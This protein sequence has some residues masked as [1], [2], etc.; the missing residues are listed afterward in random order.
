MTDCVFLCLVWTRTLS[1]DCFLKNVHSSMPL[2]Y[3]RNRTESPVLLI[4][5]ITGTP[6]NPVLGPHRF[7]TSPP[8]NPLWGSLLVEVISLFVKTPEICRHA[9]ADLGLLSGCRYYTD[10]HCYWSG[11][12]T[13]SYYSQYYTDLHRYCSDHQQILFSILYRPT[14]LLLRPPTAI[15]L[16]MIQICTAIPIC[17]NGLLSFSL[18]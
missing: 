2:G 8:S 14:L 4:M 15:I 3:E 10:L 9:Y 18:L 1:S 6:N 12:T 5:N 13:Y 7:A 17:R 16:K 11:Q